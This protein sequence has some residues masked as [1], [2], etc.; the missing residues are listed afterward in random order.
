MMA[1]IP[2]D[3]HVRRLQDCSCLESCQNCSIERVLNVAY[4][5]SHATDISS[6]H[7]DVVGHGGFRWREEVEEISRRLENFGHPRKE[8]RRP[9]PAQL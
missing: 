7:L 8:E 1:D 2:T 5:E 3:V 6:I 9:H 4:C